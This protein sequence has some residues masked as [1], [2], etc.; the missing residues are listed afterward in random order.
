MVEIDIKWVP[1]RIKG[2][3]YFQF[4][5]IDCATRWRY[6]NAYDDESSHSAIK[7]LKELLS[8]A[9]FKIKAVKTDNGSCFTNRYVGYN[10]SSDPLNPKLHVFDRLCKELN[11]PHYLIDPGKPAQ[12]GRVERSHRTD[13][14]RFY[15]E[16]IFKS[17]NDLKIKLRIW[18]IKYNNTKHCGL[19]GKTPN[20]MLKLL[21]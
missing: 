17:F 19:S 1:G 9:D 15:D 18:N 14:E 8:I 16:N 10:K 21:T 6:L 3:R 11:I 12:N 13:Q 5:A 7:F 2:K 20:Q 4:T